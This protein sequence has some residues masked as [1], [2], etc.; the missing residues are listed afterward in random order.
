MSSPVSLSPAHSSAFVIF[1][2]RDVCCV[3]TRSK[4]NGTE[5]G[6]RPVSTSL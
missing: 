1:G 6:R 3:P 5:L 4:L 2:L